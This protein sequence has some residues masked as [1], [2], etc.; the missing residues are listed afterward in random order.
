MWHPGDRSKLATASNAHR[1]VPVMLVTF[2]VTVALGLGVFL[3][4]R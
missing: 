2:A 1:I 4:V 3:V